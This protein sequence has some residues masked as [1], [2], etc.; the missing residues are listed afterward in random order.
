MLGFI[1]SI[2]LF[3]VPLGPIWDRSA[4]DLGTPWEFALFAL[5]VVAIG[6]V[7]GLIFTRTVGMAAMGYMAGA[8]V[9]AIVSL[10]TGQAA[11]FLPMVLHALAGWFVQMGNAQRLGMVR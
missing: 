10:F 8:A 9:A 7:A 3:F 6:W 1:L 5:A 11:Y 4:R 2:V